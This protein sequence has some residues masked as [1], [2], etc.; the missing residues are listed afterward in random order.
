MSKPSSS[1]SEQ[2][3]ALLLMLFLLF[4]SATTFFLYAWN[5]S[6]Q[7]I[8]RGRVT[9]IALQHAKDA[10]IGRAL[11]STSAP[12]RFPCPEHLDT[13]AEGQADTSCA[14]LPT[15]IGRLPWKTLGQ[16]KLLDG[17]GE[18][19]WYVISQ[20]Y[21]APPI[22]S[23][24]L[25][26]LQVDG[27]A[28]AAIALII[29]PGPALAGQERTEPSSSAPPQVVNYLD[30]GN[31]GGSAFVSQ[32]ANSSFND[33]VI[34]ITQA[35]LLKLL[36]KRVLAE[37]RG[38]DNLTGGLRRYY[39]ENGSQFPWADINGDGVA[40]AGQATGNLPYRPSN[41]LI[42]DATTKNWLTTNNWFP[43]V[44]Y[45][46]I[47]ADN[48]QIGLGNLVLKVSPCTTTPCP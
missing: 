38:L 13:T 19:L 35:E 6:Q 31:A 23:N 17:Y 20:N 47:A 21:T 22:N 43:L 18:P 29:A 44:S 25:P 5:K 26:Q 48:A 14:T 12:G 33:R 4:G 39:N 41:A 32:G 45:S 34:A 11:T 8:E 3:V 37:V 16:D 27:I 7:N 1:R 30:Q 9:Q 42:F 15:R 2:G 24:T 36:H 46:R 10:L 28:G 40:D